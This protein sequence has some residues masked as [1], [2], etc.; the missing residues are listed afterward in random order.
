MANYPLNKTVFNKQNY[1][2]TIDTS[3]SQVSVPPPPLADTITVA[4]FFDLYNT[5]FYDIPTNGNTNS[6]E[7][8]VKTSGDYIN[9]DQTNE[10]VQLLLDEITTLRQDL[11]TANQQIISLQVSSSNN[12]SNINQ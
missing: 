6:H 4:E 8:L 2:T 3:F 7:Y 1:E 9:F 10:D 12:L 5:L 11:L